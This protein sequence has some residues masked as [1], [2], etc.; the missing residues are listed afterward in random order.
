[1]IIKDVSCPNCR[2]NIFSYCKQKR[3]INKYNKFKWRRIYLEKNGESY[4]IKIN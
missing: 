2:I 4:E 3:E 1:M